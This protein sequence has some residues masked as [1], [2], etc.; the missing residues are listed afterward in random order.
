[1]N[2]EKRITNKS[3][4][5]KPIEIRYDVFLSHYQRTG[6]LL[7]MVVKLLL[8]KQNP[9]LHIFLDVDDLENIHD[10]KENVACTQNFMLLLTEGVFERRFVL[11][12][13]R[14]ALSLNKNII[15]LWDKERCPWPVGVPQ[16]V[17]RVLLVRAIIWNPERDFRKVVVEQ[18]LH[19]LQM[20]PGIKDLTPISSSHQTHV[21]MPISNT[22]ANHKGN[23][24]CH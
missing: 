15:L 19:K 22:N 18:I 7:A 5:K 6:G 16:D 21:P 1:M 4:E 8:E 2:E 17:E 24:L 10:L 20:A 13:V 12:E 23:K 14:T 3:N 11:E 9:F